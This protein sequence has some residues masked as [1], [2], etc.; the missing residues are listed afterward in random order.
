MT[1]QTTTND[2]NFGYNGTYNKDR[3]DNYRFTVLLQFD[4][5]SPSDKIAFIS[6]KR[7]LGN[8]VGMYAGERLLLFRVLSIMKNGVDE[9]LVPETRDIENQFISHPENILI[10]GKIVPDF[11]S[12]MDEAQT[13]DFTK[14]ELFNSML[15][16]VE[17]IRDT[18]SCPKCHWY[19]EPNVL[20][21]IGDPEKCDGQY[22]HCTDLPDG[23]TSHE[24]HK[25][26]EHWVCP[27]CGSVS[28]RY[29]DP[30][31]DS[32]MS[33]KWF[34]HSCGNVMFTEPRRAGEKQVI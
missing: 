7:D 32:G 16:N 13:S 4:V 23:S 2:E 14:I 31:C 5:K 1:M 12:V 25:H 33:V 9:I 29:S 6:M 8:H 11:S 30:G 10:D 3:F 22:L 28:I 26:D 20:C 17:K 34:C 19:H 15:D 18:P 24:R 27:K 21:R